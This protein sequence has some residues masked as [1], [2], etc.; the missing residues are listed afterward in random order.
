MERSSEK[1]SSVSL[2]FDR[3]KLNEDKS[4]AE[5]LKKDGIKKNSSPP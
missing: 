3:M 1:N 4:I 5:S 2:Q